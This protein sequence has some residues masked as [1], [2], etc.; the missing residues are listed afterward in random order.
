MNRSQYIIEALTEDATK[1]LAKL[2]ILDGYTVKQVVQKSETYLEVYNEDS[3]LIG[4]ITIG[5]SFYNPKDTT[6]FS[7]YKPYKVF[8]A[9]SIQTALNSIIK[10]ASKHMSLKTAIKDKFGIPVK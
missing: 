6:Y 4:K 9:K 10:K 7:E 8:H 2:K 1:A 3:K 5:G